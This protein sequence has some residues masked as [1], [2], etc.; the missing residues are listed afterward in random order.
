[1][2]RKGLTVKQ[3]IEAREVLESER[4][5]QGVGVFD[6]FEIGLANNTMVRKEDIPKINH[7][8]SRG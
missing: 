1:M 3:E 4:V 8:A 5:Q 6:Q 7:F 2:H